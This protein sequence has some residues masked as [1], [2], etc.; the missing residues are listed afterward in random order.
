MAFGEYDDARFSFGLSIRLTFQLVGDSAGTLCDNCIAY[1]GSPAEFIR[2]FHFI[3]V[4]CAEVDLCENRFT[5]SEQCL[6]F[7][8]PRSYSA[9]RKYIKRCS[10]NG[11]SEEGVAA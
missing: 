9:E 5:A 10:L 7:A 3:C 11:N 1:G 4:T 2:G 8:N 6:I